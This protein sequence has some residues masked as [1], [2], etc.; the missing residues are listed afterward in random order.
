MAS[1]PGKRTG[2]HFAK[3]SPSG[4][5][6]PPAAHTASHSASRPAG[7]A[8][9]PLGDARTPPSA[10]RT[11]GVSAR[12]ARATAI[13]S[14]RTRAQREAA[15][16]GKGP[17][18]APVVIGVIAAV[19]IIAI[20]AVILIPRLMKGTTDAATTVE[21]GQ[22]VDV[23]IPE[24]S[25][26]SDIAKILKDDG[27]ITDTEAFYKEVTNQ[28][29]DSSLKSGTYSLMTGATPSEVVRQLVSGP[30]STASRLT[31]A[32]G[33]TVEKT[34]AVVESSLGISSSDF[35]AQAKASNYSADY[36]FLASAANDSLEGYLCPKTYDFSGKQVTADTVIRAML[37]QYEVETASL[38]FASAEAT[39]KDKY[40]VTMSDYDI[41]I[42]A[43]VIEKEAVT[44]DDRPLVSSVFYNRMKQGM[45][46]QSDATMGYVTGGDVTADDLKTQSPYNTY[47]NTGLPPTPICTPSNESLAA[48]LSPAD[49]DYLYFLIIENGSYSNHTFSRTY[50]E[51]QAAIAAAQAAQ[52]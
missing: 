23:V 31:I 13:A 19:A 3:P 34:A 28:K 41:V 8:R 52:A 1:T 24:G 21:A 4:D 7:A 17:N 12:T 40:G 36:P 9:Q 44:D 29:A 18:K 39:I 38:D 30:N 16:S 25:G 10:G 33:L 50:E 42:L 14:P 27:I 2:S 37:D 46:L 11:Q 48:A 26:A 20:A 47:L 32:E 49:S 43:S 51:H 5:A 22:M 35:L 6:T 45:A 15:A